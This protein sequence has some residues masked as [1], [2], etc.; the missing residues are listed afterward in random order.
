MPFDSQQKAKEPKAP[1]AWT[2]DPLPE[3]FS[4]LIRLAVK[5]LEV[6]ETSSLY[7]P[8]MGHFHLPGFL[9][10]KSV[11]FVCLAG[12]VMAQT[13][14]APSGLSLVPDD[15]DQSVA[16]KLYAL[17][18]LR[19]GLVDVAL[20]VFKGKRWRPMTTLR[21]DAIGFSPDKD[22]VAIPSYDDNPEGFKARLLHIADLLETQGE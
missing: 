8:N 15:Y 13:L 19:S 17:D 20:E 12:A 18:C 16:N 10:R 5:D 4:D 2:Y 21:S 11:C 6:C 7:F 9:P 3:K 22:Y 14:N 1:Y